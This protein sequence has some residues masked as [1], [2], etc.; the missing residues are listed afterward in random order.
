MADLVDQHGRPLRPARN[1]SFNAPPQGLPGITRPG[2]T[3]DSYQNFMASVGYGTENVHGG[4][5]YG[6]NPITRERTLLEWMYRGSW[7]CGV[8]VD[9]PADDMVKM[10]VEFRK[11]P[12]EMAE[13]MEQAMQRLAL[14]QQLND[15][16]K[17]GRLY[18]GAIAVIEV[19][20]Q[21]PSTPL[22]EQS[23]GKG[24]YLGLT[25]MD[26]WMVEPSLN[27]LVRE[28]E[29]ATD[30]GLPRFY[31]VTADA[32]A[33]PRRKVHYSRVVRYEGFSLPYWQRLAENGWGMSVYERFY[34][35]LLAFDSGT[36]GV[37]QLIYKAYLRVIKIK[38]LR[39]MISTGG[40]NLQRVLN[41]IEMMRR[42]Q[43]NEGIT[44]LD[45][46]DAFET[47][48][49]SF[50]GLDA[51]LL[52]MGQQLSGAM[53]IPL[54]RLFGQSPAGL[55]S[56]GESDLRTYYDGVHQHQE[57]RL[58]RPLDVILAVMAR[59][60]GVTLPADWSYEFDPLWQMTPQEKAQ[61]AD[62]T[63]RTVLAAEE[64]GTITRERSLEELR[65]VSQ[66][67][68]VFSTITDDEIAEARAE[69]P[70]AAAMPA[71]PGPAGETAPGASEAGQ[72]ELPGQR[73]GGP[74]R[75]PALRAVAGGQRASLPV[76]IPR[77][78]LG[79]TR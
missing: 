65:R 47:T 22:R 79:G 7:I 28:N 69:M 17:W 3:G 55:N 54:V 78:H 56:T 53:Q 20:G 33:Y 26:R 40:A 63:T 45:A 24:Q 73:P 23:I 1:E 58:R 64:I 44:L 16:I 15:L 38:E 48:T 31:R 4:S 11:L 66:V 61:T 19:D 62:L 42:F 12:P 51:A 13:K 50:D 70:P 41:H 35:R 5:T 77:P 57:L 60:E 46:D 52:Q 39:T 32:P 18:G 68:G 74:P 43:T 76:A 8:A 30:R 37:A 36:Q 21:D 34:D 59:S 25:V 9:A 72:S 10:G 71:M 75:E 14:W 27:D 29:S 2:S 6:F 67:T 49:Y